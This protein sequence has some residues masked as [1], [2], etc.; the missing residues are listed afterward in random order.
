MGHCSHRVET[1]VAALGAMIGASAL[2]LV[3]CDESASGGPESDG[4]LAGDAGGDRGS[5]ASGEGS[6]E[7]VTRSRGR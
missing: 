2:V 5:D 3:A 7:G 1:I 4:G 6:A